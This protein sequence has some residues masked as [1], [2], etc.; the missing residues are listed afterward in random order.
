[1]SALAREGGVF[2]QLGVKRGGEHSGVVVVEFDR[3]VSGMGDWEDEKL[4]LIRKMRRRRKK[5][6]RRMSLRLMENWVLGFMVL[7]MYHPSLIQVA[8]LLQPGNQ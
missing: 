8:R 5:E 4:D 2:V 3:W 1:M 7:V 6:Q